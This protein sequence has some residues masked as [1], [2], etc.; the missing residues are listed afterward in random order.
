[1][2]SGQLL[3]LSRTL[4]HLDTWS[5]GCIGEGLSIWSLS[6]WDGMEQKLHSLLLKALLHRYLRT[7]SRITVFATAIVDVAEDILHAKYHAGVTR[8]LTRLRGMCPLTQQASSI[9]VDRLGYL[10]SPSEALP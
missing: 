1:M 9:F 8:R 6:D 3:D 7:L 10:I 4:I 5:V 2:A